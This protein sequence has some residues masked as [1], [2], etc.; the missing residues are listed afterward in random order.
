[1][2][3]PGKH[4]R[5]DRSLIVI[6]GE[7]LQELAHPRTVSEVWDRVRAARNDH[8]EAS[9]LTYDWFILALAFLYAISAVRLDGDH[10]AI[11][12]TR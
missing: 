9:P 12:G 10:L 7:I 6:G 5:P 2:I 3:L 4:I 8:I 1:L 11:E